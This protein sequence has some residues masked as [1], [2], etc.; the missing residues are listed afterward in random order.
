MKNESL[1]IRDFVKDLINYLPSQLGPAIVGFISIPIITRI[2]SP[3][4][5]GN[6]SLVIVSFRQACV[7][8]KS[9][10]GARLGGKRT[11]SLPVVAPQA[12]GNLKYWVEQA[13][14]ESLTGMQTW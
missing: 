5:Y 10:P 1:T 8:G 3:E 11:P 6:Y 14:Q 12:A 2:F 13:H 7:A 4:I 9:L